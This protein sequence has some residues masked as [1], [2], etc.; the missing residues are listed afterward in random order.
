MALENEDKLPS[1]SRSVLDTGSQDEA[2]A[3]AAEDDAAKGPDEVTTLKEQLANAQKLIGKHSGEVASSR[4]KIA[5]Y[6]GKIQELTPKGPSIEDQIDAISDKMENGELSLREG[7]R[8]IA[9]LSADL[10]KQ[11]A[12][13]EIETR[14]KQERVQ[15]VQQKFLADN[16]DYHEIVA[17]GA[18]QPYLDEDPLADTY[19]AF[20][21]Y[22]KDQQHQTE[23]AAALEKRGKVVAGA[24]NASKVLGKPG[25]SPRP[26]GAQPFQSSQQATDAMT[27]ALKQHR[28]QNGA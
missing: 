27:N 18:L 13:S 5:E 10:G 4:Q 26:G 28:G 17:S 14:G 9:R 23:L 21:V 3:A 19:T 12:L 1:G 11:S 16:P 15:S 24:D 22:K 6:E 7:N 20:K 8:E 2:G 25:A